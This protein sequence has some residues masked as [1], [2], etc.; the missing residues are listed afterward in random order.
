M[1]VVNFSENLDELPKAGSF[2][3]CTEKTEGE[4]PKSRIDIEEFVK[5]IFGQGRTKIDTKLVKYSVISDGERVQEGY[6]PNPTG[7]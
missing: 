1:I 6:I 5:K 4:L 7:D 3:A 2:G